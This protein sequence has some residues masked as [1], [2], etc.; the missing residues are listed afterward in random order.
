MLVLSGP[1][2]SLVLTWVDDGN[3]GTQS[4]ER[5]SIY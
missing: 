4:F 3:T 1:D 5:P 2:S